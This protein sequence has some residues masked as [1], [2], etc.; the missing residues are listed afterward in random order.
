M[1]SIIV[2]YIPIIIGDTDAVKKEKEK[3]AAEWRASIEAELKNSFYVLL[4]EDPNRTK[5]ETE[6]FF[7]PE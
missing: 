1:K 4:I 5:V 3:L 6:V 7:K 2:F